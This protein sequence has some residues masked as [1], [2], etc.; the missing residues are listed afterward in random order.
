MTERYLDTHLP[1]FAMSRRTDPATSAAAAADLHDS[2]AL[3]RQRAMVL[4]AVRRWPGSTSAELADRLACDR[5]C[6]SRR[7]PDLERAGLVRRGPA[8]R[9]SITNRSCITW[10]ATTT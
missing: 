5:Y 2:G 9:C 6:P 3:G 7:L 1:L 8:R 10:I 4:G